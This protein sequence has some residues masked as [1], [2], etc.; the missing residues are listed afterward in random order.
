MGQTKHIAVHGNRI[1]PRKS[2][3]ESLNTA[4]MNGSRYNPMSSNCGLTFISSNAADNSSVVYAVFIV[5]T[6]I[7]AITSPLIVLLNVLVMMA[8]KTK[9]QLRT[10]SNITLACLATTDL[11]VGVVV[12]PLQ[13]ASYILMIKGATHN[14]QFC[15]LTDVAM[16]VSLRCVLSSLFHLL[17]IS[18]ERYIAMK[19]SLLYANSVSET[20]IILAGGSAWIAGIVLPTGIQYLTKTS[21]AFLAILLVSAILP[22]SMFAMI[23]LNVV[24][25]MQ[26]RRQEKQ[27]IT[28]NDSSEAK[29]KLA[30]YKKAFYTIVTLLVVIFLCFIPGNICVVIMNSYSDKIPADVRHVVI[31]VISLFPVLNSLFNPLIYVVRISHFR[32]AFIQLLCRK[33]IEEARQFER[34]IF[35]GSRTRRRVSEQGERLR[36]RMAAHRENEEQ[37][38]EKLNNGN[39]IPLATRPPAELEIQEIAL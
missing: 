22:I 31:S 34:R 32:V 33:T 28:D 6:A 17:L 25:Y 11:M 2:L 5:R 24:V 10:K 29:K 9:Q 19:H 18:S 1:E 36:H 14:S 3:E 7:S 26:V 39:E 27:I 21:K 8:V 13:I 30:R 20:R 38:S 37:R 35:G 4:D 23:Y 16:A 12:Q 15:T